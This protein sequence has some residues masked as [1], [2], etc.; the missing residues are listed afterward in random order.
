MFRAIYKL[1]TIFFS[2]DDT[3]PEIWNEL[4]KLH[5]KHAASGGELTVEALRCHKM[6]RPLRRGEVCWGSGVKGQR[7]LLMGLLPCEAGA[8]GERLALETQVM[9]TVRVELS[10]KAG[11]HLQAGALSTG[12]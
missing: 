3:P 5:T 8:G 2:K 10:R 7:S 11:D 1:L 9:E 6:H 12:N 4:L